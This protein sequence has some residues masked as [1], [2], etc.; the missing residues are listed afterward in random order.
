MRPLQHPL[1]LSPDYVKIEDGEKAEAPKSEAEAAKK[2]NMHPNTFAKMRRDQ[3]GRYKAM[4]EMGNGNMQKGYELYSKEYERLKGEFFF[5]IKALR[6]SGSIVAFSK[7]VL[8][9]PYGMPQMLR[10]MTR[11]KTK[12]HHHAMFEK[13]KR[14]EGAYNRWTQS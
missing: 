2:L 1:K 9:N 12:Q 3:P 7:K 11:A 13:L 8:G 10:N 5:I 4:F 6:H 14:I